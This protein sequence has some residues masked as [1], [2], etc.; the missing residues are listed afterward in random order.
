MDLG[1]IGRWMSADAMA[2]TDGPGF[3]APWGA[4]V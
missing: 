3:R 2:K 4:L 1:S